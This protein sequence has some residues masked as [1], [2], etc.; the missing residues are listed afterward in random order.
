ML[1]AVKDVLLKMTRLGTPRV[2]LSAMTLRN[3]RDR[4]RM[5]R[6][7]LGHRKL[8]SRVLHTTRVQTALASLGK[9]T[10]PEIFDK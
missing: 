8:M 5:Q 10:W 3:I 6:Q 4:M 1:G 9:S 2:A 7:R